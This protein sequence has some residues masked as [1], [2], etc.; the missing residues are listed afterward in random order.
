MS[1]TTTAGHRR[2]LLTLLAAT[3]ALLSA[4]AAVGP[5]YR[6]PQLPAELSQ[7]LQKDFDAFDARVYQEQELPSDWWR[8][9]ADPQLDALVS[10]AIAHNTDLRVAA[11]NI[12][13]SEAVLRATQAQAGVQTQIYTPQGAPTIAYGQSSNKGVEPAGQAYG[14]YDIAFGISYEIDVAGRIRRTLEMNTANLQATAA[15]FDLA[16]TTVVARVVRA[17]GDICSLGERLAVARRSVELQQQSLA[18]L[19]RGAAAGLYSPLDLSRSRALLAQLRAAVPSLEGQRKSALYALAVLLGRRPEDFPPPLQACTATPQLPRPIPVGD[20]MALLRRRPDVRAAERELAAATA[21]IGVE[22][23]ALYPSVSF[24]AG[25]GTTARMGTDIL[26]DAAV[27]YSLGPVISWTLPNRQLAHARIDAAGAQE[28]AALARFDAQVL[29]ALQEAESALATY[30]RH[31]DSYRELEAACEESRRSLDIIRR[32]E[33]GGAASTLD[34]LDAERTLAAAESALA[35]AK[36]QLA[37]DRV[38]IF[39]ALG[40]GW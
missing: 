5:E 13:T 37:D 15:A 1:R 21:K 40:G 17:Y 16:R 31:L 8:L 12:E 34:R 26:G 29:K 6:P 14:Q 4:C 18:L 2:S 27:H 35:A 39:L 32:R 9:Y 30:A 22:T 10:E 20:G 7:R 25:L 23:A 38:Q 3:C 19:A 24:G 28:R 33:I 36:A 11:A